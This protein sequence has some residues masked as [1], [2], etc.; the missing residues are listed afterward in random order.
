MRAII[1][2]KTGRPGLPELR[3]LGTV[4]R[5]LLAVNGAAVV[6]VFARESRW[7]ALADA[8]R[9]ASARCG[10]GQA[11]YRRRH[12]RA[13]SARDVLAAS[14]RCITRLFLSACPGVV[15]GHRRGTSAGAAGEDP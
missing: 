9:D 14:H 5:I 1:N 8:C 13:P 10:A 11:R 2:Q 4:L 6:A 15:A 7:E 12:V 3:N